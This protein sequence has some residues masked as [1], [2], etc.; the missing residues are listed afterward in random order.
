MS[1]GS[2]EIIAAT[3]DKYLN[4]LAVPVRAVV[5]FPIDRAERG[6]EE[7]LEELQATLTPPEQPPDPDLLEQLKRRLET[8]LSEVQRQEIVQL[9]VKQITVHTEESPEGKRA[10]VVISYRF[11]CLVNDHTDTRVGFNYTPVSRIWNVPAA[12]RKAVDGGVSVVQ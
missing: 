8:G 5:R 1:R 7:R 9:L 4:Q 3:N 6:N 11:P 2:I 10:R 12:T